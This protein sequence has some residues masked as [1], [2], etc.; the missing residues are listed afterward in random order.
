[1]FV[2]FFVAS[3]EILHLLDGI[4]VIHLDFLFGDAVNDFHFLGIIFVVEV[5]L[6]RKILS[7]KSHFTLDY[8]VN[9]GSEEI[10]LGLSAVDFS[11]IFFDLVQTD[12]FESSLFFVPVEVV[13]VDFILG[14][15]CG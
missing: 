12:A 1:M 2:A 15:G 9:L 13:D 8:C 5:Y 4:R 6:N 7:P 11:E 10:D 3:K 14:G